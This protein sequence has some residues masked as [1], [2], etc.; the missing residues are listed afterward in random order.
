MAEGPLA[1]VRV[2]EFTQIIAGPFGCQFLADFGADVLKV[3][4]IAGEPWR[5]ASQFMPLESKTYQALNRGK[6]SISVDLADPR[7]QA[8]MHRIVA[9][10]DVVV[11]NYRP[12][13]PAR[14]AID[15]ETLSAIKPDLIYVDST[16]FGRRGPWALKPGYDIVAQGVSGLT[17]GGAR[18]DERG[19][20]LL[21]TM[22]VPVADVTT[23]YAIAMG[24]CAALF[25]RAMTGQGQLVETS[26]LANA[27]ITQSGQFMSLPPAD[28]ALRTPFLEALKRGHDTGT[29]YAELAQLRRTMMQGRQSGNIYY[30]NYNT[31]DGAIAIGNLSASLRG[32]MRAALGID[33]DPRD[34]DPEWNPRAPESVAFG[35]QLVE[36]VE[37][38]I[39]AKSTAYWIEHLE[40]AGVPV[41]PILF[42]EELIDHPQVVQNGYRVDLEHDLAGPQTMAAPPFQMSATPPTPQDAAPPLGRDT[43]AILAEAGLAGEEIAALRADGAIR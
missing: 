6:R 22:G 36:Q 33:Y 28:V 11:I 29:S 34:D 7:V 19:T 20:P 16:A 17:A 4:P 8:A 24:T 37:E 38:Q 18:F 2:L 5:L 30:R 1:G 21:P 12:D 43:D 32:K 10:V 27:L 14:L 31:A 40:A 3:E 39:R 26:L 41:G 42:P 13:V 9:T 15:Y 35:A 25:H 23:G